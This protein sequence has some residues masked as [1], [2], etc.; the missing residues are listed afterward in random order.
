MGRL[1]GYHR[2]LDRRGRPGPASS[3]S[4]MRLHMTSSPLCIVRTISIFGLGIRWN[5][6]K[7]CHAGC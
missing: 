4:G 7:V 3:G 1:S 5:I 2:N 6:L